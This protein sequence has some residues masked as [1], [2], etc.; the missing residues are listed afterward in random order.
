MNEDGVIA[1]P[2]MG[3]VDGIPYELA[4]TPATRCRAAAGALGGIRW[5]FLHML[6]TMPL[7][8]PGTVE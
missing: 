1:A 2:V 7:R 8:R 4:D 5:S 6:L 3:E